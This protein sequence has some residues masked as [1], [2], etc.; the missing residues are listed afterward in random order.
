[1][2]PLLFAATMTARVA[3]VTVTEG[4]RHASIPVAE[5]VIADIAERTGW[6]TPE[7]VRRRRAV[8]R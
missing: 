6:F 3:V 8:S 1:M 2:L 5:Q 4:Y 7:P